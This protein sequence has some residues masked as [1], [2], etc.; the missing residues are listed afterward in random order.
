MTVELSKRMQAVADMVPQG[1][2]VADV[3]CD[4]GFVSIYLVQNRISSH[5]YAADVRPGPLERAKAHIAHYGLEESITPVLSDGLQHVPVGDV[6]PESEEY[7]AAVARGSAGHSRNGADVLVAAGIGG[8]L[9]VK[10]LTDRPE[11]TEDLAYVVLEPQSE[12]WLVRRWL[13]ENG[14]VILD[15]KMVLEDGKFYPVILAVNTRWI[16]E[17]GELA[18]EIRKAADQALMDR[19]E[20]ILSPEEAAFACDWFGPCLIES[21]SAVLRSYLEHIMEKD[22]GLLAQMP[23][24]EADPEAPEAENAA[25]DESLEKAENAADDGSRERAENAADGGSREKAENAQEERMA[26][27]LERQK[28]L[29]RKIHLEQ[30]VLADMQR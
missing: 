23:E 15:E 9:T 26:R 3:G 17:A 11:K 8:R 30:T 19:L 10:I 2:I 5:V 28:Q 20:A 29:H 27:I 24:P 18:V 22:A 4:H 7:A 14:F 13:A 25:G 12:V 1:H 16:S 6:L 21:K